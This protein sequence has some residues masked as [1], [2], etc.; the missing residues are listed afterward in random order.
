MNR[1]EHPLIIKITNVVKWKSLCKPFNGLQSLLNVGF[2]SSLDICRFGI[3]LMLIAVISMIAD[4]SLS[5]QPCDDLDEFIDPITIGNTQSAGVWYVD[6][7]APAMFA[8][9]HAIPGG[10][11][12]KH[13]IAMA[14]GAINRPPGQQGTFYNTQGR[15]YDLPASTVSMKIDLYVPSTWATSNKREAGLWGTAF[16]GLM[17]ISILLSNLPVMVPIHVFADGR[18]MVPG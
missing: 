2:P 12:L 15:K 9:P 10:S 8:A 11:V 17:A 1:L 16:D 7:Y 18:T 5:A 4:Q 14:D 13:A 3:H 6:R